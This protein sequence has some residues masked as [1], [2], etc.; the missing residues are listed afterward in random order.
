VIEKLKGVDEQMEIK[1]YWLVIIICLSLSIGSMVT[2]KLLT[3]PCIK[4]TR[5][6]IEI[7]QS[8]VETSQK[9]SHLL[10]DCNKHLSA[11]VK[12][13]DYNVEVIE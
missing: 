3:E 2:N 5:D 9:C 10:T 12:L 8:C 11:C 6:A 1:W 13:I 7:T 4:N